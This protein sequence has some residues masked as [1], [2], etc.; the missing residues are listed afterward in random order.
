[1]R[2]FRRGQ[3]GRGVGGGGADCL[4]LGGRGWGFLDLDLGG[5]SF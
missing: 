1:M 5:I 3:L 4:P 2:G